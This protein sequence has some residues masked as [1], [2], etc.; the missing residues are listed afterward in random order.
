MAWRFHA[1]MSASVI[2]WPRFGP[3]W[4]NAVLPANA[5]RTAANAVALRVDMFH[6]PR[7]V[8]TPARDAVVVL[9]REAERIGHRLSGL[10]AHGDELGARRL[11]V[12]AFVPGAA[13][14]DRRPAGPVP[15]RAEAGER[16]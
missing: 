11:N 14:Q 1:A 4:A 5:N 8:D 10:A 6:L 2:G 13:L 9:V 3:G 16:L 7:G 12:A 15:R